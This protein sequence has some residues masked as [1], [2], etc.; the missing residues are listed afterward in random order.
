MRR[1]AL[2]AGDVR[3]YD[4]MVAYAIRGDSQLL[5]AE[6][7]AVHVSCPDTNVPF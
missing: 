4:N 3:L 6:R 7:L 2:P 1:I 5:H